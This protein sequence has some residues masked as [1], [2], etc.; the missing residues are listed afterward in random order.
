[1]LSV[2]PAARAWPISVMLNLPPDT[3][4]ERKRLGKAL[5]MLRDDAGLSQQSA[6][7]AMGVTAQAWQNYE[8]GRR[9]FTPELAR[10]VTRALDRDPEDLLLARERVPGAAGEDA[11]PRP[12]AD[13]IYDLPLA[14]RAVFS[15]GAGQIR[16]VAEGET[17]SLA[18]YFGPEWKVLPIVDGAMIPYVSPGGFVTYSTGRFPQPGQG[19]VIELATGELRVRRF[20]AMLS[21]ELQVAA[22][23]PQVIP[24]TIRLTEVKGVYAVGLRL[25]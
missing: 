18:D 14:G 22:I 25:G 6:A 21:G 23:F 3:P 10:K 24:E 9:R 19:C 15:G 17:L 5:A 20:E 12:R 13:H 4:A 16:G 1:M 7:D 11:R 2:S 8:Y